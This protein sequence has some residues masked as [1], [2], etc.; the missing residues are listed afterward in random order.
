MEEN[1]KLE[2]ELDEVKENEQENVQDTP[3]TEE[4]K[5][6]QKELDQI[7][8]LRL[9][10]ERE[11]IDKMLDKEHNADQETKNKTE[12]IQMKEQE[13]AKRELQL[14]VKSYILDNSLPNEIEELVDYSSKENCDKSLENVIKITNIIANKLLDEKLKG[15]A[16]LKKAKD[17]YEDE[18]Q[19]LKKAFGIE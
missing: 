19:E 12:Q 11:R 2:S 8:K 10:R 9:A 1:E 5:F 14:N 18:S 17:D 3:D 6:T 16:P 13:L 15:G 7:I 4:K